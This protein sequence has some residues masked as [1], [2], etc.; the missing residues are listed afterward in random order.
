MDHPALIQ[1]R[2]HSYLL[3]GS[4]AGQHHFLAAAIKPHFFYGCKLTIQ[5][6]NATRRPITYSHFN[7][8]ILSIIERKGGAESFRILATDSSEASGPSPFNLKR[9]KQ[10]D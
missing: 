1:R 7:P 6:D 5:S 3:G 4:F 8:L 10:P 2:E 9:R